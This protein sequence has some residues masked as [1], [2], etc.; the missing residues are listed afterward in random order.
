MVVMIYSPKPHRALFRASQATMTAEILYA[1]AYAADG[2][3]MHITTVARTAAAYCFGCDARMVPRQG[4]QRQWH[5]AH[6]WRDRCDSDRALHMAAVAAITEGIDSAI[7][8]RRPYPLKR[9]CL[10]CG[11]LIEQDIATPGAVIKTEKMLLQRDDIEMKRRALPDIAIYATDGTTTVVEVVVRHDLE[12]KTRE[13]YQQKAIPVYRVYPDWQSLP[14]LQHAAS[15]R[16]ALNMPSPWCTDCRQRAEQAAKQQAEQT[17]AQ[18]TKLAECDLMARSVPELYIPELPRPAQLR[19]FC[20]DIEPGDC[21]I[22][23][24]TGV[25]M[26]GSR[27]VPHRAQPRWNFEDPTTGV[28]ICVAIYPSKLRSDNYGHLIGQACILTCWQE[29]R[30]RTGN[31]NFQ[32]K[33]NAMPQAAT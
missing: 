8:T 10:R 28:G 6:M 15:A 16:D 19:G 33:L 26:P 24:F 1:V 29:G 18:Q 23:I 25:D 32:F 31:R 9:A 20:K 13:V 7:R 2:Q 11:Q 12:H 5:F 22:G 14:E 17:R 30:S 3:L 21:I 4:P 27:H